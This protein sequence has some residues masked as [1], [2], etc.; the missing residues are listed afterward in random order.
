MGITGNPCRLLKNPTT[1]LQRLCCELPAIR[2]SDE[3]L[4]ETLTFRAASTIY[5]CSTCGQCDAVRFSST[6]NPPPTGWAVIS[7]L[8]AHDL[9]SNDEPYVHSRSCRSGQEAT[10]E[11]LLPLHS[12]S[13]LRM[14]RAGSAVLR[15]QLSSYYQKQL[16]QEAVAGLPGI[17]GIVNQAEVID[18]AFAVPALT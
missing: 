10:R 18:G 12:R 6:Y 7:Q 17:I 2:V 1:R 16:A 11:F 3:K 14:R 5:R 4:F 15:G 13:H 8:W 9:H